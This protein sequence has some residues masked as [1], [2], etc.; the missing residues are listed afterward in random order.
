MLE[1]LTTS[2]PSGLV[3]GLLACL[4]CGAA[5]GGIG[6][7]FGYRTAEALGKADLANLKSQHA[8]QRAAADKERLEQ[9]RQQINRANQVDQELQHT[10]QQLVTPNMS[11]R[12][13]SPMSRPSTCRGRPLRLLLSLVACS[14][15]AG[16]ATST[17]PSEAPLCVPAPQA[18]TPPSLME[19]PGPPPVL[20]K[21]YWKAGSP[22]Q[23]SLPLPR[24]TVVGLWEF[25]PNSSRFSVRNDRIWM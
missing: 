16:C 15:L 11:L 25:E 2:L 8:D 22:P 6:Y 23:T 14:L 10:K 4:V 7:G 20:Q 13:E 21:N 12:S 17:L 1:R 9:L 19:P 3:V 18:P 24:I 5:G